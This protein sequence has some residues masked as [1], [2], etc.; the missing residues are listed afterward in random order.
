M[1]PVAAASDAV[2]FL[3]V[4]AVALLHL[5][6]ADEARPAVEKLLATG[7]RGPDLLDLCRRQGLL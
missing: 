1:A 5:D 4:Y 3:H 6:R 2:V 7:W